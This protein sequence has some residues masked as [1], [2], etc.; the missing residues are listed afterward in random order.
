MTNE[1]R[2]RTQCSQNRVVS[3]TRMQDGTREDYELLERYE[4][5]YVRELPDRILAALEELEHSPR[6]LSGEPARAFAAGCD[7][8]AQGRCR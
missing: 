7:A 5:D 3:F 4:R 8:C 2:N 1:D 6:R